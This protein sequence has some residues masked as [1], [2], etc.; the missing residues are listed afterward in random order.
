[1]EFLI[2]NGFKNVYA[3]GSEDD[4]WL[5]VFPEI[6]SSNTGM[7]ICYLKNYN[8][9]KVKSFLRKFWRGIDD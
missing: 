3:K 5:E 8:W 9:N 2:S 1:M 4:K 6:M 7:T